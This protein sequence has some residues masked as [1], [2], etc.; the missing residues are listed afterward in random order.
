MS[1]LWAGG[2]GLS[3]DRVDPARL[4][5]RLRPPLAG[6]LE[7]HQEVGSTNDLL[8]A[9][10]RRGSPEGTV[11]CAD[12][13]TTGRGR[14]GRE[15]Q[16]VP[17]QALAMSVLLRPPAHVGRDAGVLSLLVATAVAEGIGPDAKV[18]WPNDVVLDDRKVSGIL[19]EAAWEGATLAWVVAGM[20][21]NVRGAP[22]VVGG[23][24]PVGALDDRDPNLSREDVAGAILVALGRR[25]ESLCAEGPQTLVRAFTDRDALA[26]R[27]VRVRQRG[28][29]REGSADGMTEDGALRLRTAGGVETVTSADRLELLEP[30]P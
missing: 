30:T 15:W 22:D 7:W 28:S 1:V 24:W 25:Y 14:L 21:V 4:E 5:G 13:Q 12:H 2:G 11:I 3:E 19:L 18:A 27:I 6:P 29:V 16:D 10:A 20:G 9:R 23:T 17:G 26:G 8:A